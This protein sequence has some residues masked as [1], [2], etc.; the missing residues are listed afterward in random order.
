[1]V[2]RSNFIYFIYF[3]HMKYP[4]VGKDKNEILYNIEDGNYTFPEEFIE[5]SSQEIL[6]LIQQC[7]KVNPSDRISAKKAIDHPFFL[8]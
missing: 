2:M 7:L 4:F 5:K 6:D 3:S 8:Y 1:M